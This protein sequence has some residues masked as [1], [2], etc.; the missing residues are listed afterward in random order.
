MLLHGP[1]MQLAGLL[2]LS[3]LSQWAAWRL[4]LPSILLLLTSGVAVGP[5]FGFVHPDQLFGDLLVPIVSLSVAVILYEGGMTL[6][7]RELYKQQIPSVVFRIVTIGVL[8][9]WALG[10]ATAHYIIGFRWV[11]SVLLGAILVVTGPT[12]IGPMLRHLR[13]RGRIGLVLKW[14]GIIVDPLGAILAVLVFTVL[15]KS[16]LHIGLAAAS[17]EFAAT[18]LVGVLLGVAAA[19][20]LVIALQ[21]FWVPDSLHN[22]VSLMLMFAAFTAANAVHQE[23]GLLAATVM[24]IALANQ[25]RVSI[26]HILEFKETLSVLL[27]AGVFVILAARLQPQHLGGVVW[28]GLLFVGALMVVVRPLSIITATIRSSLSWRE[29]MF[30]ACIAPR[31]IV[32]VALASVLSMEL[33]A[34]GFPRGGEL[35]PVVFLTVFATVLVYGLC[36][37]P[38]ARHLGLVQVN[39]QGILFVGAHGWA[40][41]MAHELQSAGCPVLLIDTDRDN[42]RE[43]RMAGLPC[44]YGSALAERTREEIDYSGLGRLLAVTRNNEVNTLAC[45]HYREDF[46]RGEVYQLAFPLNKQGRLEAIPKGQHGRLL[47]GKDL[48]FDRLSEAFG[49]PPRIHRTKLTHEFGYEAFKAKY[50]DRIIELFIVKQNGVVQ[51]CTGDQQVFA[52]EA[53][54]LIIFTPT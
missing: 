40:R 20:I 25:Q 2:I 29:R 7:F 6:R 8:I 9:S 46:G 18:L 41:A 36:A 15:R 52:P 21:R 49:K 44:M 28:E 48:A 53:G 1:L 5:I 45:A 27:I 37:G 16:E 54:D 51:V 33:V 13:L 34:T 24:G 22:S 47:F 31:G 4:R 39:P 43:A 3:I 10:A 26:R 12:V 30:L 50:G 23:A 38:L 42:A 35:V 14:E 19:A 17:L 32:A 11:P